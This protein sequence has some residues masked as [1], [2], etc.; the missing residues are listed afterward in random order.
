MLLSKIYARI[1]YEAD[2]LKPA[3]RKSYAQC[4][5][6][7]I[8]RFYLHQKK[9]FYVDIGAFHPKKLSNT[10]HFYLKGWN[11]I[12]IDGSKR[13]IELFN[14]MRPDDINI[15]CCVGMIKDI[16]E[17]EFYIFETAELNTIKK[18]NLSDIYLYHNQS[19][20]KIEKIPFL[21][22]ESILDKHLPP[23]TSIDLLSIDAEGA[24]EEI[25][26]SNNWDKYHPK[27]VIVEKHCSIYDFMN[28]EMH[29]FL[30]NQNYTLGGYSRHSFIFHE[31]TYS[32]F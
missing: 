10:Y 3:Y 8:A 29:Q 9:G 30:I 21:S 23:N 11:G 20:I 28:T 2:K 14:K 1:K 32:E 25:L 27:L 7:M 19:P 5:E 22:L 15:N 17:V 24:D 31:L 12:N 6:D 4:G 16:S 13:A 18:E 26:N